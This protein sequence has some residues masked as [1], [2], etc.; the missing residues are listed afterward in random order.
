MADERRKQRRLTVP[1]ECT[2]ALA[3]GSTFAS[4]RVSNIS[5]GGCFVDSRVVSRVGDATEIS[6][7]LFGTP[8]ILKGTVVSVHPGIGFA[9][10]FSHLDKPTTRRLLR[11]LDT[12]FKDD[13]K[14]AT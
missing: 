14:K 12:A 8:T 1:L 13:K 11:F 9:L 2:W 3:T 5:A 7:P 4:I 10:Q 6:V